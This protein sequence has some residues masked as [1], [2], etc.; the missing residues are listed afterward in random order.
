MPMFVDE[1]ART[2]PESC[3]VVLLDNSSAHRAKALTLP[4]TIVFLFQPPHCPELNPAERV[5]EDLC[6]TC[7]WQR[8]AHI[9]VLEDG[10]I[11]QLEQYHPSRLKSLTG[12][13][14]LLKAYYAVCL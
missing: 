3:N 9:D 7:A 12:D 11:A 5:W 8:F 10:L 13:S 14:Y 1:R 4:H 2:Y 6:R